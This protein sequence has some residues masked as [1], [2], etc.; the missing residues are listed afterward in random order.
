MILL[1][2]IR[3]EVHHRVVLTLEETLH[4]EVAREKPL[5][6]NRR[7]SGSGMEG[8]TNGVSSSSDSSGPTATSRKIRVAG[9]RVK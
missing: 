6:S 4:K 5:A 8:G 1:Q 2:R 9:V 7:R 3:E